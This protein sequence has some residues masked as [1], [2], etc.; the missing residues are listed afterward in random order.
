MSLT[1]LDIQDYGSPL[2]V[3]PLLKGFLPVALA[4]SLACARG[5]VLPPAPTDKLHYPAW[6][7]TFGDQLLVVNLDQDLAYDDGALVALGQTDGLVSGGVPAPNMAGKLLV[8]DDAA[9]AGC[10]SG[11]GAP[12]TVP[13]AL[14]AGHIEE[15]LFEVSLADDGSAPPFSSPKRIPLRP[16]SSSSSFGVGYSCGA[17]GSPRAWVSYQLGR[18]QVG[19]V[20]QVDLSA[21]PRTAGAIGAIVQVNVGGGPARSFAYDAAHDR[22]YFTGE[23][24]DLKAPL[25]WIDVGAGCKDFPDGVQDERL[26]GCHVDAGYDLGLQLGGAEPNEIALSSTTFPCTAGGF[27]GSCRRAYLSVRMY[28]AQLAAAIGTRPSDDIGGRL[29]VLEL[30]E[31]G[32]GRP[33]PQWIRDLDIGMSAGDVHVIPRP[34]MPDLVAVTALDDHLLWLYDDDAG[35]MVKV[36]G[37]DASGVPSLGHQPTAIASRDMGGGVVRLFVTS[38]QDHWVSAIDVPLADPSAAT[39]VPDPTDA[40]KPWRLGVTP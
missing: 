18:N 40:S 7:A 25:R 26:G 28:D 9:A 16:I 6:M 29:V 14:V 36:F 11:F 23:E 34:G 39:L 37:R 35:A 19:Y 24:H 12:F 21:D 22:L 38:Y 33:E 17:D 30:P 27:T 10:I 8:V 5:A 2:P 3:S 13:F 4:L 31:G 1:T 20:T 32:L 15:S